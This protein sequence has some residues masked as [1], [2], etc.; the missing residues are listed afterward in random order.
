FE[1][2]LHPAVSSPAHKSTNSLR[3][4][5]HDFMQSSIAKSMQ[6]PAT[7]QRGSHHKC[8]PHKLPPPPFLH[9]SSPLPYFASRRSENRVSGHG[10][11]KTGRFATIPGP[12]ARG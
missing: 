4:T 7:N 12:E 9:L 2:S 1:D 11:R 10:D 5:T 6:Q 8:K 3:P